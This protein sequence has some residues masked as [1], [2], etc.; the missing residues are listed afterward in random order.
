MFYSRSAHYNY[1]MAQNK[2]SDQESPFAFEEVFFSR[3]DPRGVIE[4]GNSVFQRVSEHPWENLL[5]KPHNLIRHPEMPKGVFHLFWETIKA[6]QPIGAY[7]KNLSRTRKYYWVYALALP[8]SGGY[9]SMRF[10]P[11]CPLLG[12]VEDEYKKLKTLEETQK[13]TPK[14]SQEQLLEDLLGL[15]FT[16]YQDFMTKALMQELQSRQ[17]H[18]GKP[19]LN[20]LIALQ[21]LFLCGQ[22]LQEIVERMRVAYRISA[23][24][25]LNLEIKALRAGDNAKA[26]GKIS[27]MYQKVSEEVEK[28]M[29]GFNEVTSMVVKQVQ[30]IQYSVCALILQAEVLTF[31]S[32]ETNAGPINTANEILLL[33]DLETSALKQ[34]GLNLKSIEE[35]ILTFELKIAGLRNQSLSLEIIRLTGKIE[36]S[37]IKDTYVEFQSLIDELSTFRNCLITALS[38]IEEIHGDLIFLTSRIKEQVQTLKVD[39]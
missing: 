24:V 29:S 13:L 26:L 36:A 22:K 14:A 18:L 21:K 27:S 10:K 33:K 25:P 3:T 32:H 1:E 17:T 4:S 2:I 39:R 8:I 11:S 34:V 6:S 38:E 15:G 7:V 35:V 20:V 19:P 5:G 9:L 23:L 16:S 12:I 30:E 37:H 28:E 31:F